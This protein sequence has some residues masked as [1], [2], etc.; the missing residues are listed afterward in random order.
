MRSIWLP[1]LAVSFLFSIAFP[2]IFTMSVEYIVKDPDT[3]GFIA[4]P[5]SWDF[6]LTIEMEQ[7]FTEYIKK[8]TDEASMETVI[9]GRLCVPVCRC[10]CFYE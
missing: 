3:A 8:Q 5:N 7:Q 1:I 2:A 9:T 4:N 10:Y 6:K